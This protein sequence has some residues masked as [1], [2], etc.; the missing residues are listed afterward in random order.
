[1]ALPTSGPLS[2]RDIAAAFSGGT[3]IALSQYHAGSGLVPAGTSGTYGPV[4]SSGTLSIKNFYG[5]G[6]SATLTILVVAGG[7][8]G[9]NGQ[10]GGGGAGGVEYVPALSV[11]PTSTFN[12]A[13]GTGGA[14][15]TNGNPSSFTGPLIS[16]TSV[17][18]GAGGNP[19]Q[20]GGSGGGG[21]SA[22]GANHAGGAAVA[23]TGDTFY[24]HAGGTGY[25]SDPGGS[26]NYQRGGGGGGAGAAGTN[27]ARSG[28]SQGGAGVY[29]AAFATYGASGYFGGGGGGG[30]YQSLSGSQIG[31]G[32]AGGVGGGGTVGSAPAG[33]AG[34]G[35]GGAGSCT[36]E[37][38]GQTNAGP[39][40]LGTVLVQY[41]ATR[42]LWLGGTVTQAGSTYTH[43]FTANGTMV[44]IPASVLIT[45][46]G[47]GAGGSSGNDTTGGA[48]GG[49]AVIGQLTV[50]SGTTAAIAVGYPG[51]KGNGVEGGTTAIT[52]L[53]STQAYATGGFGNGGPPC[54]FCAGSPQYAVGHGYGG[55]LQLSGGYGGGWNNNAVGGAG[56]AGTFN[57][58]TYYAAG[59]GGSGQDFGSS[60]NPG[61]AGGGAWAGGGGTGVHSG[62]GSDGGAYGGGGGGA[63]NYNGGSGSG[64]QGVMVITYTSPIQRATGGTVTSSG[65]GFATVWQHV[66]TSSGNFTIN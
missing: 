62:H 12:I 1:M 60:N 40:G 25:F 22:N 56:G 49:G 37:F 63:G 51:G 31:Y 20:S 29:I 28:G 39:G 64:A 11:S 38:A 21:A 47:I 57:G 13:V 3:P 41:T 50:S 59:G 4:P 55:S 65:S 8:G 58:V 19:G 16:I 44:P 52:Y 27:G 10:H 6:N 43:A 54:G 36:G 23:G 26:A 24:G 14:M 66:F 30:G 35:G 9:D 15:N 5:T 61:G 34:T 42:Q 32:T 2:L 18:G 48:S 33:V 46:Y 45:Y 17:G 53:G 7:G